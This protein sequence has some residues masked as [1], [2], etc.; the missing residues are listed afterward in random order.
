MRLCENTRNFPGCWISRCNSGT[1]DTA[2]STSTWPATSPLTM[3]L[4]LLNDTTSACKRWLLEHL[5]ILRDEHRQARQDRRDT[6]SE[7]GRCL[8][9]A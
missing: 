5:L 3:S 6:R 1:S 4:L 2:G 8:R 9:A 7:P